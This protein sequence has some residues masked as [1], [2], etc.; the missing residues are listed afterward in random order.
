MKR[1]IGSIQR[2]PAAIVAVLVAQMG[3]GIW[4]ARLANSDPH[5]AVESNYYN[6]AVNWDATMAQARTDRALG[7]KAATTLTRTS[8]RG[9][10]L[11]VTLVDSLGGVLQADSVQVEAL[12]IA[13]ASQPDSLALRPDGVGYTAP[14]VD[15]GAG[16]WEVNVRAVK[17]RD[18]F[19]ARLRTE[20]Q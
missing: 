16:L 14:I 9:A 12:A 10:A 7:W 6:K 17:G 11:R 3:F 19:T 20:L 1:G 5:F 13:H 18:V 8:G 2:W 15:A 4:M